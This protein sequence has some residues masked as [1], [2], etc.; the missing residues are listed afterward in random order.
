M[1][2]IIEMRGIQ[3]HFGAVHALRNVNF[4]LIPAR[5]W[6]SWATTRPANRR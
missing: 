4:H 1:T 3:K 2:P 5:S 6:G